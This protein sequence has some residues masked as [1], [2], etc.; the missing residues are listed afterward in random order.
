MHL[1]ELVHKPHNSYFKKSMKVFFVFICS[2]F[3]LVVFAQ[4][5]REYKTNFQI[6][7]PKIDGILDEDV[8][9]AIPITANFTQTIP[10][11]DE[12]SVYQSEVKLFYTTNKL[13]EARWVA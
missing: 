2:I 6:S 3:S 1:V 13:I 7:S 8:W 11:P 10:K 5:R 4:D 9:K 12:P